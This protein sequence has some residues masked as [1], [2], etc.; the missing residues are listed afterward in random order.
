MEL[1]TGLIDLGY[2]LDGDELHE[3]VELGGPI[4]GL[5]PARMA[6]LERAVALLHLIA[7]VSYYKTCFAPEIS[8]ETDLP[9]PDLAA[10][11][12]H[13]YTR[14][15]AARVRDWLVTPHAGLRG[16][17]GRAAGVVRAPGIQAA[18]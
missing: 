2:A 1:A 18:T 11:L 14:G 9:D 13:L 8:I 17:A 6:A 10:F 5:D 16:M 4:A 12:H 7:G 15:L 3:Q